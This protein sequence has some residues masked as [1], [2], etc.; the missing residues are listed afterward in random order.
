MF[1]QNK[2]GPKRDIRQNVCKMLHPL[3]TPKAFSRE[4]RFPVFGTSD[5]TSHPLKTPKHFSRKQE[6]PFLGHPCE[7]FGHFGPYFCIVCFFTFFQI[8]I[9]ESINGLTKCAPKKFR[10]L[11]SAARFCTK[12]FRHIGFWTFIFVH[13]LK[14]F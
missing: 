6:T 14:F 9:N 10:K 4:T 2:N 5:K 7:R 11:P 3:K 13:F 12:R 8:E 1:F